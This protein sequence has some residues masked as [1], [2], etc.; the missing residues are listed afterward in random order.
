MICVASLGGKKSNNKKTPASFFRIRKSVELKVRKQSY[1]LSFQT[2]KDICARIMAMH[3]FYSLLK[4][5]K[6]SKSS[7]SFVFKC[8]DLVFFVMPSF[9]PHTDVC[10]L[11]KK[12][13]EK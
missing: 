5:I 8:K 9:F 13:T 11:T 3:V 6:N 12:I 7:E 1:F 2:E 10:S 4:G